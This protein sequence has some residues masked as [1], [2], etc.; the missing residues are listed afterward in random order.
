MGSPKPFAKLF[1]QAQLGQIL[2]QRDQNENYQHGVSITFD[3]GEDGLNPV[4]IFIAVKDTGISVERAIHAADQMFA[5]FDEEMAFAA[6][7]NQRKD[8][9]RLM[10]LGY[11]STPI[12]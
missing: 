11:R 3:S 6:V 1:T 7:R 10:R 9:R 4:V 2:V 12:T 5:N 8:I